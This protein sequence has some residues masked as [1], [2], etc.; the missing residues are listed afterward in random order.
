MGQGEITLVQDPE[1]KRR[2]LQTVMEHY[3]GSK[4]QVEF[5]DAMLNRVAI[6]KLNAKNITGK[7]HK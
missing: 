1:E 3:S 5:P 6:L 2:G 7:Q 4:E